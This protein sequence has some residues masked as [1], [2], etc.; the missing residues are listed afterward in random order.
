MDSKPESA[1]AMTKPS[2]SLAQCVLYAAPVAAF[3]LMTGAMN[4]AQALYAKYFGLSLATIATVLLLS[5]IFDAFTDPLIG[6]LSDRYQTYHGTRKPFIIAG[7]LLFVISA[8]FL[9][10]PGEFAPLTSI[11]PTD[12]DSRQ[13]SAIYFVLALFAFYLAWT[14][15]D[16]PHLAWAVRSRPVVRTRIASI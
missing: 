11:D 13:V 5:R 7:A 12:T 1:E 10:I 2:M 14:L 6:T 3:S 4:I 15:F 8:Y 16:I 9:F